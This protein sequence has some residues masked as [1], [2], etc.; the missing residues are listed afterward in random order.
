MPL[1]ESKRTGKQEYISIETL[2]RMRE[3]GMI[4]RFKIISTK[5]IAPVNEPQIQKAV[6]DFMNRPTQKEGIVPVK[7]YVQDELEEMTVAQLKQIAT[8]RG[9]EFG[10][11]IRK[12]ELVELIIES[13]ISEQTE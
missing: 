12:A 2:E 9:K 11:N 5:D 13:N 10:G 3:S 4:R 6:T 1:I 8:E 7:F